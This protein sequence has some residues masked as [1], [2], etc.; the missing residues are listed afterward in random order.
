[1]SLQ[2]PIIT[3]RG[4]AYEVGYQ[5]GVAARE[6]MRA[7]HAE[8]LAEYR[9][10]WDALLRQSTPFRDATRQHLPRVLEELRG[11]A[12]GANI[13]FDDLFLMSVEELLYE[14][15]RGATSP[16]T[17][18]LRGEGGSLLPSPSG[19]RVGDE[20]HKGCSD[21][22]A[23]PPA[24]RDGHV[25]LAHNNDL[26]ASAREQLVVTKLRVADEPEIL[27][28][29]VGGWFISIGMNNAGIALTGNQLNANDSRA[30]I[31]RLLMVRD[32]LAQ[33]TLDAALKAALHPA[34]ASSYNNILSA[35]DGQIVNVEGSATD[36]AL[37]TAAENGGAI[38][39]TNHYLADKM[40]RFEADA[41]HAA[42]SATRCARALDYAKKYR[43]QID[44]E[45]CARFL[46]DHVYAPW[47]VCKHAGQSVTVFSAI[48]DLT[49]T[50]MWLAAG[51]PCQNEFTPHAFD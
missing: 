37:T 4:N 50:R 12:E 34:R 38:A 28:V 11:V 8:T 48:I 46:R 21:L 33:H 10:Q 22:A 35:R 27:A 29:T 42:M 36:A 24:T 20:G 5:I 3:A 39:H 40:L 19:R 31:P 7:M 1:M 2:I 9:A 18:L 14:E 17:P 44:Y 45:I 6:K 30:G 25:W 32:M 15:V 51:N 49:A 13:P 43:G 26:G 16:P 41:P 47:S 23:A